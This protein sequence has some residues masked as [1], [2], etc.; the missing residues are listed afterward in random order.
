MNI[1][2]TLLNA[3]RSGAMSQAGRQLGLQ[4]GDAEVLLRKLV[5]AL[6]GGL[7]RNVAS[8]GGLESLTRA[9]AGGGH[10]RYLD[11]P[12]ALQNAVPDGNA[13]LGHLFGSKEVSRSVA[14][15]VSADTGVDTAMIKKFLPVVA[16]AV[17]G[18]LSK[19]TSAGANLQSA[20]SGGLLGSLLDS[21]GDGI[22]LDD[23]VALGKKFL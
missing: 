23:L 13:I 12:S 4:E 6:T 21:G 16:A 18:A 11:D 19:Q 14:G 17:M 10:Q 8:T 2:E 7:K 3:Q 20:S 9:L 22:G 5:P 1:L 15:K